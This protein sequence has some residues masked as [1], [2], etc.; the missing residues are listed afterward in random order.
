VLLTEVM[1]SVTRAWIRLTHVQVPFVPEA[2]AAHVKAAAL[3][4]VF[5]LL[6]FVVLAGLDPTSAVRKSAN[7]HAA[8]LDERLHVLRKERSGA[9]IA[10]LQAVAV[11]GVI[12]LGVQLG[13]P[14]LGLL[15]FLIAVGPSIY[16]EAAVKARRR[17]LET[18]VHGFALN[19][20]NAMRT[21]ANIG[22][23]IRIASQLTGGP[24]GQ[25]IE[26]ML[27]QMSVGGSLEEA[28][29]DLA[30]RVNAQA[31][32][33]L[34]TALVIGRKT[35]G[36]LPRLMEGT[37]ASLREIH[38]LEAFAA[39]VMSDPRRSFAMMAAAP[40]LG[41]LGV[42]RLLAMVV[43]PF[44]AT[45]QGQQAIASCCVAYVVCLLA[46]WSFVKVDI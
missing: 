36:D 31:L 22:D 6:F 11:L 17:A 3:G 16:L 38:R 44:L 9:R 28:L 34:V 10:A 5:L 14:A 42:K 45:P 25:E 20:A 12:A 39:K 23:S 26:V 7:E 33:V 29:E 40:P 41:F 46:G 30:K 1:P 32:D 4:A 19:L 2:S 35:G 24:L 21:T 18:Q 8:R 37:A 13:K 27:A 43:D 15:A